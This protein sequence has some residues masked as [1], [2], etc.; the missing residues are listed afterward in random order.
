MIALSVRFTSGEKDEHSPILVSLFRP[1]SG[2]A[3]SPARFQ[4]PLGDAQLA[5]LRWYLEAD[6]H[7]IYDA[8]LRLGYLRSRTKR[9]A[10]TAW[11]QTA[12]ARY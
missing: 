5:D 11:T 2:A 9:T 3:T 10:L 6:R 8:T 1:D 12:W 7:G 4:P